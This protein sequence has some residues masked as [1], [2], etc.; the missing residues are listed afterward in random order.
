MLM[1]TDPGD[2]VLDPTCG[3]GTT[4]FVAEQW[5]RRWITCDTSRVALALARTRLM[6]AKFPFYLLADSL[7][8]LKKESE[9]AG[10]LPPD[11]KTEGDIKKGFVFK[12][13]PHVTLKA[14]ANNE[15]IDAIHAEFA[16]KAEKALAAMNKAAKKTWQEW[17]VPRELPT[18]ASASFRISHMEFWTLRRER[19]QAID[20]SIARRADTELLYDQPY[21]DNKRIRVTGPFTVESLSPHRVISADEE[22]PASEAEAQKTTGATQFVTMI[23]DNLKTAGVQQAHKVDRITFTALT[24]WPGEL[25]CAESHHGP[26]RNVAAKAG[27]RALSPRASRAAEVTR[28]AWP[29]CPLLFSRRLACSSPAGVPPVNYQT[30]ESQPYR[31]ALSM[32]SMETRGET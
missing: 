23:L 19:Q 29:R 27:P 7:E 12:R 18:D 31:A 22:R 6:T 5:G 9:L 4:A 17:E 15:E 16:P 30:L 21:E 1:T 20:D 2:L 8:G 32:R 24:P 26:G 14:I 11:I 3:S 25:V 28:T 13:V 10:K